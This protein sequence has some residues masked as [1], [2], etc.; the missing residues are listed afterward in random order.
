MVEIIACANYE[1]VSY[2]DIPV[3]CGGNSKKQFWAMHEIKAQ[4]RVS[5]H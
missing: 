5:G 1:S 2:G 3:W 4:E